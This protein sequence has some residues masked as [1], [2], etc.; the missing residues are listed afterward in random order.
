[1]RNIDPTFIRMFLM[2]METHNVT[3]ASRLLN[4]SQAAASQQ[5]KRL[6][7]ML[8]QTLFERTKRG[9]FPTPAA[10][11][12]AVHAREFISIN[13]RV[14]QIAGAQQFEGNVRIGCPDDVVGPF[15]PNIIRSFSAIYPNVW[16]SLDCR[17]TPE[18]HVEIDAGN[19]DLIITTEEEP[20]SEGSTVLLE[21]RLVFFGAKG[22]RAHLKQPLPVSIG[23]T[24]YGL[25]EATIRSLEEAKIAWR[26]VSEVNHIEVISALVRADIAIAPLL[27]STVPPTFDVLDGKQG[28]PTLPRFKI[29]LYHSNFATDE[30][31]L[32][33][34][35]HIVTHF[36]SIRSNQRQ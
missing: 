30:R 12:I 1:M 9:L 2:V 8:G 6:E 32:A 19:L 15:L 21:D 4:V 22:G 3:K 20:A 25:R 24:T 14:C 29:V 16:I 10:F 33:L 7:E 34:K 13:D 17:T 23:S 5:I 26:A 28:L 27:R 35:E 31:V 11:R 36:Q 18:L